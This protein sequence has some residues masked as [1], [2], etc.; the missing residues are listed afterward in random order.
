MSQNREQHQQKLNKETYP[1]KK[2]REELIKEVGKNLDSLIGAGI[3]TR[4]HMKCDFCI[5]YSTIKKMRE[6]NLTVSMDT[7]EKVMYAMAYY[8]DCHRRKIEA[9]EDG[10]EKTQKLNAIPELENKLEEIYG[11]AAQTALNL[12]KDGIDLRQIVKQQ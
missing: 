8:L 1:K 6:T 2:V 12:A 7:L 3:I 5:D 9:E 4:Y 11:L 10:I